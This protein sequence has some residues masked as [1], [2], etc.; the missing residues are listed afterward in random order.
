MH[1][2]EQSFIC[3]SSLCSVISKGREWVAFKNPNPQSST[4]RTRGECKIKRQRGI[5]SQVVSDR[6]YYAYHL[7]VRDGPQPPLFYGG[8]LFQQFVV[9]IWANC[10]QRRL[11]QILLDMSFTRDYRMLL[12]I[13][14][15][16]KKILGFW[17][18]NSFFSLLMW[19]VL[20]L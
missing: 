3:C 7:H 2:P 13:I 6:C 18:T 16:M 9:D 15:M 1:H 19:G 12:C 11:N 20:G 10:E 17:N 8:K 4:K 5:G 14:G